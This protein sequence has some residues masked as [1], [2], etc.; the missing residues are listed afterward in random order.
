MNEDL[1]HIKQLI[2]S[3]NN[4][5]LYIGFYML[6]NTASDFVSTFEQ[7]FNFR[8]EWNERHREQYFIKLEE[9]E[10]VVHFQFYS[11]KGKG[12]VFLCRVYMGRNKIYYKKGLQIRNLHHTKNECFLKAADYLES[13]LQTDMK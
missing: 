5:N 3:N 11:L 2:T 10:L 12:K 1:K 8:Y 7:M 9:Q 4:S 13:Y 6:K